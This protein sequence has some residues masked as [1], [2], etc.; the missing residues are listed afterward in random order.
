MLTRQRAE[1]LA[2]IAAQDQVRVASRMSDDRWVFAVF[3]HR[4]VLEDM[5]QVSRH[6]GK[7]Q[8]SVFTP[9]WG[10]ASRLLRTARLDLR[11]RRSLQKLLPGGV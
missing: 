5:K 10:A 2:P 11:Q 8:L 1:Q 7:D 6:P 9:G 3:N 4:G